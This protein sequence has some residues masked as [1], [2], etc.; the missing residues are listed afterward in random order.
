M[1]CTNSKIE[2]EI[3]Q[4]KKE[5]SVQAI[6]QNTLQVEFLYLMNELKD[7]QQKLKKYEEEVTWLNKEI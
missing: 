6:E 1:G 3:V 2:S 5:M 4:I 7:I